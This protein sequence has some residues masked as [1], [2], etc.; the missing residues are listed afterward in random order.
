MAKAFTRE[1]RFELSALMLAVG[2]VITFIS[3]IGLF[4]PKLPDYLIG[5]QPAI[6]AIGY[7]L[8]WLLVIGPIMLVGGAWWLID[9]VR[10]SL[11]LLKYLK[12]DSKAKFVKNLEEIEYLAWV[13]PRKYE[14][15]VLDK[16][17]QFKV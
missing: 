17:R 15:L 13:L 1:Y 7:W 16:K 3:A 11:E 6:K 8:Y 14:D 2:V 5:F 10:K 12:V 9:S 4:V